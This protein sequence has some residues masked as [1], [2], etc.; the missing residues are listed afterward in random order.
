MH[1]QFG[2]TKNFFRADITGPHIGIGKEEA[3][4]GC[5]TVFIFQRCLG[6]CIL[7]C[8]ERHLQTA[9]V[10]DILT[11]CQLSVGIHT[12]SNLYTVKKVNHHLCTLFK[13]FGIF[14]SPPIFQVTLF[15]ILPALHAAGL[16]S[17]FLN[18]I[19]SL[20]YYNVRKIPPLISK[21]NVLFCDFFEYRLRYAQRFPFRQLLS[22]QPKQKCSGDSHTAPAAFSAFSLF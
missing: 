5:K 14:F 8:L 17:R 19:L 20:L 7:K 2:Q 21:R 11:Q 3:L 10:S 1:I 9:M 16:Y 13:I 22:G 4:F 6:C 18:G 12:R 15:V